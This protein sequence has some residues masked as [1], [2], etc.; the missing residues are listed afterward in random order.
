MFHLAFFFPFV[1][2][3]VLELLMLLNTLMN[4]TAHIINMIHIFAVIRHTG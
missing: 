3:E 1:A 4:H 2:A